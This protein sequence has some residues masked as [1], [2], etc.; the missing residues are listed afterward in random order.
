MSLS[1]RQPASLVL[2][3]QACKREMGRKKSDCITF[4]SVSSSLLSTFFSEL[5]SCLC[6]LSTFSCRAW[7]KEETVSESVSLTGWR[8]K[9]KQLEVCVVSC[10]SDAQWYTLICSYIWGDEWHRLNL[11]KRATEETRA[12]KMD[13]ANPR[14]F[15][16][17]MTEGRT[18]GQWGEM[19]PMISFCVLTG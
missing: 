18:E 8:G 3:W 13:R 19:Q 6:R 7:G 1:K 15:K 4:S 9:E 11:N 2:A 5:C 17:Q 10:V 12:I 14:I 16:T